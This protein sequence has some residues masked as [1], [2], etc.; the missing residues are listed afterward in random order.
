MQVDLYTDAKA[1]DT[2]REEW[3]QL[4]PQSYSDTLFQ[5]PAWLGAWWQVFGAEG[6]LRLITVRDG[7]GNLV[8]V[9]PLFVAG[10]MAEDS[11]PVPALSY[12]RPMPRPSASLHQ[13]V[14][15]VGG[16]EVSDYLDVAVHRGHG[17]A[18]YQALFDALQ[19]DASWEWIDLHCL[20]AGSPT[21]EAF[22]KGAVAAG[23]RVALVQ[24]DVCP[25]IDLPASWP[26]Y[27]AMLSRK[28]RH[29]L[30]RKMRRVERSGQVRITEASDPATLDDQLAAF[31]ALHEASAPDKAGFMSD[32]RMR[33]FFG[34]V[35]R[36]ALA[37]GW[38]DLS[39]LALDGRLA[40][41][42]LCFRYGDAV[43]VYNSGFDPQAW[44][45]LSPGLALFAHRIRQ[46]IESGVRVF[47]FMQGDERYKYDL[48]AQ[49]RPVHRLFIRRG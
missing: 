18:V 25:A 35:A 38:L 16:T 26:E 24:E 1:F 14:L 41:S 2:L 11:E 37:N 22:G 17:A 31:V 21:P 33:A 45:G 49:D 3:D 23:Q 6:G 5:R 40:A 48:G 47:D 10:V 27:L 32:P 39:F 30:R 19:E 42:L 8:G 44:P 13:T 43:L 9:A 7:R 20:P 29:E 15:L 46:A 4:L 36:V 34:L 28:E 12:E